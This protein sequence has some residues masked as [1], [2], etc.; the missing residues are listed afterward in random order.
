MAASGPCIALS[1]LC[2]LCSAWLPKP[3]LLGS[4]LSLSRHTCVSRLVSST[5]QWLLSP[6]FPHGPAVTLPLQLGALSPGSWD[7]DPP[8]SV[9]HPLFQSNLHAAARVVFAN[10]GC[11][12][13][14]CIRQFTT[15]LSPSRA[16]VTLTRLLRAMGSVVLPPSFSLAF[17]AQT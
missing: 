16:V 14:P 1:S 5:S 12:T 6:S 2:G 9:L 11:H 10:F 17:N 3:F 4:A 8:L 15:S 13:C 7:S